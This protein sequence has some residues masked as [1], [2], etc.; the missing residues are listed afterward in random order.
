M[1][2]K[3]IA[4]Y[5]YFQDEERVADLL[6]VYVFHG[7]R[8]ICGADI[9]EKDSRVTGIFGRLRRKISIQKYRDLIRRIALGTSFVIVGLEHQD[10]I[11]Y[12]M[13]V[14]VMLEDAANYDE[15]MRKI[16]KIHRKEQDL[17]SAGWLGGFSASDRLEPVVT[18]VLYYGKVPWDGAKDLHQMLNLHHIPPEIAGLVNNY[19]LHILEI[20]NY[21]E[22]ELFQTDIR[23]VFHF[24]QCSQDKTAMAALTAREA[25]R[26]QTMDEDTFD[27]I[28]ALTGSEEL[29]AVKEVCMEEGGKIDM[30]RAIKEMIADGKMEGLLEGRVKGKLEGSRSKAETVAKNMFMRGMSAE[31]AAA[32]CEEDLEQVRAWYYKWSK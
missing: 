17:H 2:K 1:G 27:V 19:S 18:I 26:F 32:I 16:Q 4:L 23:D 25:A 29:E 7:R 3:D 22:T 13:P 20:H 14:R 8:V 6:N 11:H 15:Q 30:C 28:A 5:R 9:R 21:P 10:Q 12:A 24:V 31:D